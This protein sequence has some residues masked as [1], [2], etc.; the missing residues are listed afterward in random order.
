MN[1]FIVLQ[2]VYQRRIESKPPPSLTLCDFTAKLKGTTA[3]GRWCVVFRRR[4]GSQLI[5][6]GFFLLVSSSLGPFHRVPFFFNYSLCSQSFCVIHIHDCLQGG[7]QGPVSTPQALNWFSK[8]LRQKLG[9]CF[10]L[11]IKP[12]FFSHLSLS[13]ADNWRWICRGMTRRIFF[14]TLLLCKARIAEQTFCHNLLFFLSARSCPT[15]WWRVS[16][17]SSGTSSPRDWRAN[18]MTDKECGCW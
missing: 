16:C 6:F 10:F 18:S 14:S 1:L 15:W 12:V 8:M 4:W 17:L 13:S 7:G 9:C 11:E 3:P 2:Q 5:P